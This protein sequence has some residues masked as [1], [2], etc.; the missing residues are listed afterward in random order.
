MKTSTATQPIGPTTGR[1]DDPRAPRFRSPRPGPGG[2][3]GPPTDAVDI[4]PDDVLSADATET[5][6]ASKGREVLGSSQDVSVP[7]TLEASCSRNEEVE[8]TSG[9]FG[10][11][12]RY[13]LPVH[14]LQAI[15]APVLLRALSV[16]LTTEDAYWTAEQRKTLEHIR[17]Q[18]EGAREAWEHITEQLKDAA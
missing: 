5:A 4:T 13:G 10:V 1:A 2:S 15:D 12:G 9:I 6:T 3:Q 8:D 18:V 17:S 14:T 11:G 16:A 7:H